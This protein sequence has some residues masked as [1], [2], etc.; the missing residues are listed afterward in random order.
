MAYKKKSLT[1]LSKEEV[2]LIGNNQV[3][4]LGD[5]DS[6]RA[7]LRKEFGA[8]TAIDDEDN[9][10]SFIKTNID[11]LD[12]LLGG[13][14][15]QGRMTEVAGR[16]G[17]G[18]SSLGIHML[19][20]IQKQGGLGVIIDTE[21]GGAGDRFRLA[22]FGVDPKK[23]I[24]SVEDIAEKVFSQIERTANYIVKNNIKAPS[25]VIVD[26]VFGLVA[27]AELE[28]DMDAQFY[29]GSAKVI[30][31][32]I[33]RTKTICRESNLAALF[34][35]QSRIKI[36]GMTNAWTG[37]EYTTPGGDALKFQAITRLFLERGKTLGDTKAPE[38]HVVKA[39]I[40]K[41]KT[42]G[43]MN[44][45]LPIRFY[46]DDRNYSNAGTCY[47][48]LNDAK[49]WGTGTWKT[50][51]MPDGSEKRIQSD[52]AFMELFNASEENR[53]HFVNLMKSCFSNLALNDNADHVSTE[54]MEDIIL[55]SET[56]D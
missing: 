12:Y 51:I 54:V 4:N 25:L 7:D 43:S 18:K 42:A 52:T 50:I 15:P 31:K 36:G 46:Y 13:G 22:H 21:S 8:D 17:T 28:A 5:L 1:C 2:D 49:T 34:I 27:K 47:D 38:G 30:S 33:R 44:R 37:P 29:G 45:V 6:F 40:I 24:V 56:G 39:K 35:N 20:N 48:I 55:G 32:G 3:S 23:C 16:E 41:C 10:S 53:Q 11:A 19:A 9:V 14:L 26:S